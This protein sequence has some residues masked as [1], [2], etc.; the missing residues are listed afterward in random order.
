[1][2]YSDVTMTF[3]IEDVVVRAEEKYKLVMETKKSAELKGLAKF[4]QEET[5]NVWINILENDDEESIS[6]LK[7][8][9]KKFCK[10]YKKIQDENST[11]DSYLTMHFLKKMEKDGAKDIIL[12]YF[13]YS[14][15]F[16]D[17][18]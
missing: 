14:D 1:M 4:G 8:N 12:N 5:I 16:S 10:E 3:K 17:R 15:L 2:N 9:Q 18:V 6:A 7:K 13:D 11:T